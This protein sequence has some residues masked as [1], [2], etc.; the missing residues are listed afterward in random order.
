M[1]RIPEICR[2][3][4]GLN[5]ALVL[6]VILI[7]LPIFIAGRGSAE[8]VQGINDCRK[9]KNDK[10]RLNCYDAFAT[11]VD[12]CREIGDE[13]K[14]QACRNGLVMRFSECTKITG[15]AEIQKCYD[16]LKLC[17]D[18]AAKI[19]D[20]NKLTKRFYDS[21]AK[22]EYLKRQWR[23]DED[24]TL[25]R[26]SIAPYRSN[27][28]LPITYVESPNEKPQKE[29]NPN[30][31][32]KNAETAF[33]LSLKWLIWPKHGT[34][35]GRWSAWFAYTQRSFWQFYNTANSSP[36]RETN[37]EPEFLI[38]YRPDGDF[39]GLHGRF[40]NFGINHQSNGQS[41]S[42]SRS[43]NR[44]V[45]NTGFER[46]NFAVILRG[47]MR[48]QESAASDDNRDITDYMGYWE[49]WMYY[50]FNDPNLGVHRFGAMLRNNLNPG[51]NR[52]AQQIEWTIP[53]FHSNTL[54]FYIQYFNGYGESLIDYNHNINRIGAG[55]LF[56]D[57]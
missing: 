31:E 1:G 8:E 21:T 41:G 30:N 42:L 15:G 54:G 2:S 7:L 33:Q 57:W 18:D 40:F 50:F 4:C 12:R 37:Y 29:A 28:F 39:L 19:K 34:E 6:A 14:K 23:I 49:L 3:N 36:F 56:M 43:W 35:E 32:L 38:N 44:I 10:E 55:V 13:T 5:A 46:D 48:L 52:G 47:W 11:L 53:L 25:G 51:N 17:M 26:F 9:F 45:A 27:Y 16:K 24:S 20:D 22:G